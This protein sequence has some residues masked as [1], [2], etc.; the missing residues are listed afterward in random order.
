MLE[1][2][3]K[4]SLI[5]LYTRQSGT[6]WPV[7]GR[8]IEWRLGILRKFVK[9]DASLEDVQKVA[10]ALTIQRQIETELDQYQQGLQLLSA[11]LQQD[12]ITEDEFIERV[13][14]ITA[15]IYF[16]AY[17]D[18]SQTDNEAARQ[19]TEDARIALDTLGVGAGTVVD[20]TTIEAAIPDMEAR[21]NIDS[22]LAISAT[23]AIGLTGHDFLY[24]ITLWVNTALG[25]FTWGQLHRADDPF[26]EW[27]YTPLKDHCDDCYR[28]NRQVHTAKEWLASGFWPRN[29]NL[30]C[31]GWAC[32]CFFVEV[33]GPSQ[34][35]F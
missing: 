19:L 29:S 3:L 25:V 28:L 35:D 12:E 1:H 10:S 7:L 34:G 23:S 22:Q 32:G 33:N 6:D 27:A 18:G 13:E 15:A 14:V 5:Y 20:Q 9:R 16:I 26:Y 8:A 2:K 17:L 21:S 11:Q 24:R 4:Q 31:G 30:A